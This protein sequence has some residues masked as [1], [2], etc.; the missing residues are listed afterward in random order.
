MTDQRTT[1]AGE[2]AE[3][4]PGAWASDPAGS[5]EASAHDLETD[6]SVEATVAEIEQTRQEM[7]GTVEAIGDRLAPGNMVKDATQAVRNATVGK[8]EDM[9]SQASGFIGGATSTAQGAG[10]GLVDTIKRNPVPALMTGV[11]IA[12]LWKSYSGGSGS[13]DPWASQSSWSANRTGSYG[14]YKPLA[15]SGGSG[16]GN[17]F[18]AVG[19]KVSGVGDKVSGAGETVGS[20][21]GQVTDSVGSAAG[22]VGGTA[23]DVAG[24]ARSA[25]GSATQF[26]GDNALAAAAIAVAAGAAIGLIIPATETERRVIGDAGTKAIDTAKTTVTETIAKAESAESAPS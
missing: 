26:I 19:D 9:A 17:V 13:Q 21:A 4:A 2:A 23:R 18:E 12:W 15:S 25:A 10:G 6:Q 8:V 22:A 5:V 16:P 1:S 3:P 7:T 11:G 20:A 14:E 24:N